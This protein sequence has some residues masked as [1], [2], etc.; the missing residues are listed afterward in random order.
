ML[1]IPLIVLLVTLPSLGDSDKFSLRVLPSDEKNKVMIVTQPF[2]PPRLE[3]KILAGTPK[4][5]L[6]NCQQVDEIREHVDHKD[7]VVIVECADGIKL[8]LKGVVMQ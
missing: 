2:V 4:T 6:Y 7:T 5:Y 8:E 3:Y 1:R